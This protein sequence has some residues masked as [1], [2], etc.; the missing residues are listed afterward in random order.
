MLARYK[1]FF[2]QVTRDEHHRTNLIHSAILLSGMTCVLMLASGML[3]GWIGIAGAVCSVLAIALLAP[4]IKPSQV[5]AL[6]RATHIP[7]STTQLSSLV[8]VL[9]WRAQLPVRPSL[10]VV[11]SMT[12]NAFAVG[13]H[14]SSAIAVTEGLLR[15]LSLR[16]IAGVIAHEM[17]HIKHN[18]LW[19]MG[20]ADLI[21]RFLQSLSYVALFLAVLNVFA[22][23]N[24]EPTVPWLGILLL[25]TAPALSSLLQ[26]ALSRTREY[27]ADASAVSLT[28]DP[29]G[30]AAALRNV[31]NGTGRFWEDLMLPVPARRVA[32]PS[33]LRTHP[34]TDDRIQRLLELAATP[35]L[36]PLVIVEQPMVS[37]VGL[38]PGDLR[39]RYRWPGL[40]Y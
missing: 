4:R 36:E 39:P 20:L 24:E 3:W 11:P 8:D 18:D 12:L 7:P 37:L 6:Y 19:L 40:W 15:R 26:L 33:L 1:A 30:L 23:I 32:Q 29:M 13:T 28:G 25:Y 16:E 31:D 34:E 2:D 22:L 17:S 21:T 38:G 5:M 27:Q 35:N 9:A 10:Y 14:S